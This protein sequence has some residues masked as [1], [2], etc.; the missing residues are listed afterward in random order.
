MRG[1]GEDDPDKLE[2]QQY[3][4]RVRSVSTLFLRGSYN[5]VE[6]IEKLGFTYVVDENENGDEIGEERSARPITAD[7]VSLVSYLESTVSPDEHWLTLWRN[8]TR[9]DDTPFSLW[10]RYFRAGN[11]QLKNLL[12][13]GLDRVPTDRGPRVG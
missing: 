12:L 4:K 7:Q 6:E 13:F 10:R 3:R 9:L 2:L 5:A 8:E 1:D 11:T